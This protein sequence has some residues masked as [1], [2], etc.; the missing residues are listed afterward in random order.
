MLERR[1]VIL[2]KCFAWKK[3][4]PSNDKKTSGEAVI[5]Q[6]R[7]KIIRKNCIDKNKEKQSTFY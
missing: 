7:L 2:L 4:A 6:E 5:Q 1:L 3:Y